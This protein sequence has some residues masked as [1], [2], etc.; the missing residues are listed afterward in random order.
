MKG[1]YKAYKAGY[2]GWI[3]LILT[4]LYF[5]FHPNT[6]RLLKTR[7]IGQEERVSGSYYDDT[8]DD[9]VNYAN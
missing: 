9:E 3:F 6:L 4:I 1:I 7:P 8:Q 5:L 2:L